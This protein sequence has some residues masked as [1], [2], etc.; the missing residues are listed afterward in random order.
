[1]KHLL[2][3]ISGITLGSSALYFWYCEM[4]SDGFVGW[5]SRAFDT[6]RGKNFIAL[7]QPAGELFLVP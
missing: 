5:F 4:F 3:I 1:M 2:L 6:N 7:S